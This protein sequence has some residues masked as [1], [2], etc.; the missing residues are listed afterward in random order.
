MQF[1]CRLTTL[2]SKQNYWLVTKEK[3]QYSRCYLV[4]HKTAT[5]SCKNFNAY[6]SKKHLSLST[7]VLN[8]R[9]PPRKQ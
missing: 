9:D 3:G 7:I 8:S 4:N 5:L 6:G 1:N 2:S